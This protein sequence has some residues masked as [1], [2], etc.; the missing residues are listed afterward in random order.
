M[1]QWGGLGCR[2]RCLLKGL[3]WV[4]VISV[5]GS[6]GARIEAGIRSEA[7]ESVNLETVGSHGRMQNGEMLQPDIQTQRKHCLVCFLK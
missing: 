4:W 3:G 7:E 2:G 5:L 1:E 6:F